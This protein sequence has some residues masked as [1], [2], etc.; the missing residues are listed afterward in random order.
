[1][2]DSVRTVLRWMYHRG[3]IGGSHT[4]EGNI[5]RKWRFLPKKEMK[6]A[7]EEWE[8]CIKQLNWVL[9]YKSTGENHVSLNPRKIPEIERE[10][11]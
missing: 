6:D 1:M 11:Q 9:R 10:I 3:K 7:L 4:P 8:H 2:K 5:L